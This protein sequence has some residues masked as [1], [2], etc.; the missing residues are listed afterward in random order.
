M[1]SAQ[2][3]TIA[4]TVTS[5]QTETVQ[6]LAIP[7]SNI[8]KVRFQ[9]AN[10][11]KFSQLYLYSYSMDCMLIHFSTD[12]LRNAVNFSTDNFLFLGPLGGALSLSLFRAL[13]Y[14]KKT[15]RPLIPKEVLQNIAIEL[16]KD[17]LDA[18]LVGII[19]AA[20]NHIAGRPAS[21]IPAAEMAAVNVFATGGMR[22]LVQS[23]VS[24]YKGDGFFKRKN[25]YDELQQVEVEQVGHAQEPTDG[26]TVLAGDEDSGY[27]SV[28][29]NRQQ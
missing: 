2:T 9:G 10:V 26:N 1:Q 5:E 22:T 25:Q 24:W 21:S 16:G 17:L 18:E 4:P 23:A 15:N 29:L 3:P 12:S 20:I 7:A 11:A 19:Y 27:T 14:V 8:S 6:I 28:I 13:D